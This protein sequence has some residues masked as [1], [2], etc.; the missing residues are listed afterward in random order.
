[1]RV[2]A[3]AATAME[4]VAEC[5]DGA[6]S[7]AASF[8]ADDEMDEVVD[9]V[10]AVAGEAIVVEVKEWKRVKGKLWGLVRWTPD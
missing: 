5:S 6:S 1:M 10:A 2:A 8:G 9:G 7:E 4:V 3:R